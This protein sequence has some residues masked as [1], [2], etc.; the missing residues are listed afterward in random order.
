MVRCILTMLQEGDYYN[1]TGAFVKVKAD[2]K[3]QA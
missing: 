2:K 3:R 1:K